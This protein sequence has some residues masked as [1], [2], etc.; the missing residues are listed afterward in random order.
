MRVELGVGM[1]LGRGVRLGDGVVVGMLV[2]DL[3][4]GVETGSPV[5]KLQARSRRGINRAI[6]R[7]FTSIPQRGGK[8]RSPS[9]FVYCLF[10]IMNDGV[11]VLY[12][13]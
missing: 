5:I 2:R 13:F 11:L 8:K 10:F 3:R 12:R 6:L 4:V 9:A 7:R 1:R